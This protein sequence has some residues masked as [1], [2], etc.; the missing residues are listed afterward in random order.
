MKEL[1]A[2][3]NSEVFR[4]VVTLIVPGFYATS[5][6]SLYLLQQFP[7]LKEEIDVYPG[8]A[9][10]VFL[11][12]I[13]TVGLIAEEVGA[14]IEFHFDQAL[15]KR[16]GYRDHYKEWF[17]YL[18][19]AFEKEPVGHRYLRS[20]VLRLKF[21]LGMTVSTLPF[22]IGTSMLGIPWL[23]RLLII[24]LATLLACYL[25]FEARCSNET[26]SELRR[27]MLMKEWN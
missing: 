23:S 22:A 9:T 18:R 19:L 14:R 12:I 17:A 2:T 11:L 13:L 24:V 15:A 16:A 27:E 3:F 10:T 5:T 7:R 8:V 4:P 26:L 21:E 1:T 6:I 20:L 25:F